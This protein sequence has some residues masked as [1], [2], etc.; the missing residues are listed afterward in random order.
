MWSN[1]FKKFVFKCNRFIHVLCSNTHRF[2]CHTDL[3]VFCTAYYKE[4]SSIKKQTTTTLAPKY[5]RFMLT[6]H[7]L[8]THTNILTPT[9]IPTTYVYE[10]NVMK[11]CKIEK[12]NNKNFA[13]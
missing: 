7:T 13:A 10:R 12:K 6:S 4:K 2:A 5:F 8:N 9:S 3:L 1:F 11:I